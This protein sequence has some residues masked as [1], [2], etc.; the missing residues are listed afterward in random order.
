MSQRVPNC[1]VDDSNIPTA[2]KFPLPNFN[3]I[4]HEVPMLGYQVGELPCKKGQ[5]S[6]YEGSNGN[7]TTW[8]KPR[9][10]GGTLE[11][12]VNQHV[13]ENC[14]KLVAMDA[15]V[16]C[17]KQG[18][19]KAVESGRLGA[20]RESSSTRVASRARVAAQEEVG[21]RAG[22]V[23]RLP[24]TLE[25]SGCKDWSVSGS[26]TCRRELSVTFNSA[27]TGSPENTTSA[28]RQCTGT[29]TNDDRDSIS[30]LIS[31]S[32]VPDEDYMAAKVERSSGSNKRIKANSV[33]HNQSERRRRDKINQRMK[34]LQKLVP[35]SSKT[36]KASMLDEVI[37][38]MKQ[39]QAQVQ[40][41]NWMKMYTT[42]M[43]PITMQQQQQQ[44]KMSMMMAQMGMGM[45]MG[46]GMNKDMVMNMNSM[47]IPGIPPMLPFPPFMPMVSC[48]DQLQGTPEKSV[49]MDAYSKM[50]SLYDQ[51]LFHPPASSSKN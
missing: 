43:L 17:S 31:Q 46:M 2:S 36:D 50:A 15:L 30:H 37:Q 47:N 38:Y 4:S 48:G 26:E 13:S 29:T 28:G 12:I 18:T 6:T 9:T 5:P 32:E 7:L 39:L 1:D 19:R 3:F 41:M 34:E 40:M 14:Y 42:M 51:Q 44:L 33:V 10:S 11:S 8:D 23:A 22:M 20:C 27:T 25:L 21:K 16:P 24:T 35:N 49:T 45:G